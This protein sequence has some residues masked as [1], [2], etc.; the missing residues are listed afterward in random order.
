MS[1]IISL[2]YK[3]LWASSGWIYQ[4]FSALI[5]CENDTICPENVLNYNNWY[6][7]CIPPAIFFN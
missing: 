4:H 3:L 6:A 1:S 7:F 2:R 5:F